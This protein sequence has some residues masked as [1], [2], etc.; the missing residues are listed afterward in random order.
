MPSFRT[1]SN[2][3]IAA[4]FREAQTPYHQIAQA[5]E[6]KSEIAKLTERVKAGEADAAVLFL[7]F[8]PTL[9]TLREASTRSRAN[10][11]GVQ[12]LTAIRRF[13]LAHGY[14][15]ASLDEA[16]SETILKTVPTDSYSGQPMRYAIINGK[17]TVYSVG[18]D[19]NDDGGRADWKYGQQPGDYLF[20]LAPLPGTGP[21]PKVAAVPE[22]TDTPVAT[23]AQPTPKPTSAPRVWTSTVGTKVKAEFVEVQDNIA[24]LKKSDGRVLRVPLDKLSEQDREWI[25]Q[26]V[27]R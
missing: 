26:V 6:T 17:P 12:L 7:L 14:L 5:S 21:R 25:R 23:P 2:N 27:Q 24:V 10:L 9:D 4:A 15:P 19:L 11:V 13:E 3:C 1:R 18:K 20:A 8:V 16:A 22:T